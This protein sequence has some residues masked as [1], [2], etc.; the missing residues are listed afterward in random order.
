MISKII[1]NY[2]SIEEQLILITAKNTT[3]LSRVQYV[4]ILTFL[5]FVAL[6]NSFRKQE[7]ST[8]CEKSAI[9]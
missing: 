3:E 6:L 7:K 8:D 1:L 9:K 2:I 5:A 4:K